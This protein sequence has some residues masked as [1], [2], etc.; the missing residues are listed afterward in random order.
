MAYKPVDGIKGQVCSFGY[1]LAATW[2]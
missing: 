1:K 2:R